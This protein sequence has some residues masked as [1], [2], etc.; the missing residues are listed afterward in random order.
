MPVSFQRTLLPASI[1][2]LTGWAA[3][4][5][6]QT[7]Y[8]SGQNVVPVYEGWERNAD[9]SFSMAFGY[10]NRNYEEQLDIPVGSNNKFEPGP[11]DQGQPEHFYRRR[12]Q[13]VFK[14]KVPKDWGAKD[15]VWTISSAGHTEKAYGTLLPFR[16]LGNLVYQENRGG[17]GELN[18]P[19]EPNQAPTIEMVGS[20]NRTVKVQE[21]LALTV[22]VTDDGH[23]KPRAR[24]VAA[25][26]AST[27]IRDSDGAVVATGPERTGPPRENP[28]TQAV[29]KLDPGVTLGVTWIVYRS[30]PGEVTFDPM[31]I[32][33]VDGKAA[34]KVRFSK[35]GTYRL[36]AYADDGVL[37][38]PLDVTVTV[39]GSN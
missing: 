28:L 16:E 24:R 10:M 18:Y 14:V 21:A 13:F 36:R 25:P 8:A 7:R 31:R 22:E 34:T 6:A 23:P 20:A 4:S 3:P 15:L 33:V 12:Q 38:T 32:K 11:P 29:V 19:E 2:L 1:L 26:A 9:G 37:I 39:E 5:M 30:G 35:A 27:A 17:P